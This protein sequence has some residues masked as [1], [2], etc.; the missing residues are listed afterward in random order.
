[1]HQ[2]LRAGKIDR[3]TTIPLAPMETCAFNMDI[4]QKMITQPINNRSEILYRQKQ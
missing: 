4:E 1:M 3:K 2:T